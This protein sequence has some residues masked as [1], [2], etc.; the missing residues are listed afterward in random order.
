MSPRFSQWEEGVAQSTALLWLRAHKDL[1]PRKTV[2]HAV[3]GLMPSETSFFAIVDLRFQ[4]LSWIARSLRRMC[5]SKAPSIRSAPTVQ[6]PKKANQPTRYTFTCL[7]QAS[8]ELPQIRG[9][10][11]RTFASIR[12]FERFDSNTSTLPSS[13]SYRR[14]KPRKCRS[15]GRATALFASFTFRRRRLSMNDLTFAITR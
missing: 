15:S 13:G 12:S 11:S 5:A 3:F 6:T 4:C 14:R 2:D 7:M 10:S 9:V 8:T 1:R